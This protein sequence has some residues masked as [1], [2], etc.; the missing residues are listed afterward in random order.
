MRSAPPLSAARR[1]RRHRYRRDFL[2]FKPLIDTPE[3]LGTASA[4][5][6]LPTTLT[7][8]ANARIGISASE[9][10]EAGDLVVNV[11]GDAIGIRGGPA[12]EVF[13][14]A[15]REE[16]EVVEVEIG[17]GCPPC[18]VTLHVFDRWTR[19]FAIATGTVS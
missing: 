7:L 5:D 1:R 6:P 17:A 19:P 11:N 14:L 3:D 15:W 9:A 18:T 4:G 8:P 13:P 2:E 16:D 10:V 12:D